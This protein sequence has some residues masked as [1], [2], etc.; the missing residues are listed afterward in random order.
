MTAPLSLATAWSTLPAP[1]SRPPLL[2]LVPPLADDPLAQLPLPLDETETTVGPA[3]GV[4]PDAERAAGALLRALAEVLA[5]RR[6]PAQV[7]PALV[8]RVAHLI[9]HLVRSGAADGMRLAGV[10]LQSPRVGVVEAC[11]RLASPE[12]SVAFTM[13][14]EKRPRRWA[15]TILEAALA[16]DSRMPARS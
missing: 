11:A 15:V 5:G 6:P 14:V 13:R 2:R 9:D 16:P 4:A 1:P 12:R 10:R 7:R 8:P 3:S